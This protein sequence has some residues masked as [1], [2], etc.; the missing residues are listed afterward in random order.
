MAANVAVQENERGSN[1][2]QT[3]EFHNCAVDA[4]ELA[5]SGQK[6]LEYEALNSR[7]W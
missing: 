4:N 3:S 6:R 5:P 2:L 7:M 1:G